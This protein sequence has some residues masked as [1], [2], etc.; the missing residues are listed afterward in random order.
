MVS[1]SLIKN[2][3]ENKLKDKDIHLDHYAF[4]YNKTNNDK[5]KKELQYYIIPIWHSKY[6]ITITK[7]E[8][9]FNKIKDFSIE[10]IK[11]TY[12]IET[13][14]TIETLNSLQRKIDN[15]I[16]DLV[17]M[18]NDLKIKYNYKQDKNENIISYIFSIY[19]NS[20]FLDLDS[21]N[22]IDMISNNFI[23]KIEK[24]NK[25]KKIIKNKNIKEDL[26]KNKMNKIFINNKY[27]LASEIELFLIDAERIPVDNLYIFKYKDFKHY[28]DKDKIICI[29]YD[30]Y[31]TPISYLSLYDY[32]Y[33]SLLINEEWNL[34]LPISKYIKKDLI[35]K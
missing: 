1:N 5:T 11:N 35:I 34:E 26:I 6:D 9:Y 28:K 32:Q 30:N 8:K 31:L 27:L 18:K 13:E 2:Y 12:K 19:K 7:K 24:I 20:I 17:E 3:I 25:I 33:S 14:K 10:L 29:L 23:N 16:Y 22:L 21:N 4:K 15:Y